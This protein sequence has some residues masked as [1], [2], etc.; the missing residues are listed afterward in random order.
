MKEPRKTCSSDHGG[1][2]R[3]GD[4]GN[5]IGTLSIAGKKLYRS[6]TRA[7]YTDRFLPLSGLNNIFGKSL[8]IYGDFGP[9]ARG[10][11]LACSM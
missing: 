1:T 2:C 5:R 8:V 6:I 4:I 7:V 11:R 3:L 10:E 9:T